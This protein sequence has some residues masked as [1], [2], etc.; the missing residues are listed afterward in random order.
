M[1]Y[2]LITLSTSLT[3]QPNACG[4]VRETGSLA[5]LLPGCRPVAIEPWRKYVENYWK[6]A[7]HSIN[8]SKA[9][10]P[11]PGFPAV[12]LFSSLGGENEADKP[13]KAILISTTNPAQTLPNLNKFVP[14]IKNAFTVVIDIFPTRTAQL[15][16]VV[17]PASFLYE[18][19]GVY[20]CS[21][22]RSFLTQK[23]IEPLEGTKADLWIA[24][25]IA[26]RMGLEKFIAWSNEEDIVKM[27]E[28]AWNDYIGCTA[29]TEKTLA[30]ATYKR[31]MESTTGVQ[32][33]CP[34]EDHPGT[35]KRYV[36]GMDPVFDDPKKYGYEIPE[37]ADMFFY[38]RKD[39]KINVFMRDAEPKASEKISKEYP[40]LMTTGRVIEQWHTGTMTMR[41]PETAAAHPNSYIE[42][43]VND[44]KKLGLSQGDM[45]KV[46]SVRGENVLPV[47]VVNMTLEGVCFVPMHDQKG[48]RMVNFICSDVVDATSGE[49]D[50]KVSAV[51]ITKVSGPQKVDDKFVVTKSELDSP[52]FS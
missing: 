2:G 42:I 15:A 30:G 4:G 46:E 34:S 27:A 3:G 22:R 7:E 36:R 52:T 21:E 14:N 31:L 37:D 24:C 29:N 43:H 32:W 26:K 47:R 5:H 18:K 51:K 1:V 44:A 25:Q 17:L 35:Y 10:N 23:A 8:P 33:P 39:G 9:I 11:K 6:V 41:I 49:P 40:F 19:G 12:K 48:A 50:Y 13:V 16:S 45:V 20:G 28:M 38:G